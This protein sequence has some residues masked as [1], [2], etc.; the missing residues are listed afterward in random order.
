MMKPFL[1][2]FV[3]FAFAVNFIA[4]DSSS[5]PDDNDPPVITDE[6][7]AEK[8]S[9]EYDGSDIS[10]DFTNGTDIKIVAQNNATQPHGNI[11]ISQVENERYFNSKNHLIF[12]FGEITSLYNFEFKHTLPEALVE[13]DIVMILYSPDNSN[14]EMQALEVDFV[15]NSGTGEITSAFAAPE[16]LSSGKTDQ[17]QGGTKYT[18]LVISWSDRQALSEKPQEKIVNMPYYEQPGGSCWA[19]AAAMYSRG[20]TSDKQKEIQIIDFLKYMEHST[21]DEGMGLYDFK[22]YLSAS[23][24]FKVR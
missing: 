17:A 13:E 19:T 9:H 12:D 4:C 24:C 10:F 8:I 16:E 15:Y 3:I 18:R 23:K 7:I 21:L 20:Y 1:K 5:D 14:S 2:F 6:S 11:T 22:M